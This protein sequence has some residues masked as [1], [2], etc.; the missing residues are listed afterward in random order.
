[1]EQGSCAQKRNP[2]TRWFTDSNYAAFI[3]AIIAGL[4]THAVIMIRQ[5]VCADPVLF[6][7]WYK[8]ES[9]FLFNQGRWATNIFTVLRGYL[10]EPVL[11]TVITV[12]S[13]ALSAAMVSDLFELKE[14]KW[15]AM[16]GAAMAVHPFVANSLMYYSTGGTLIYAAAVLSIWIV[17]KSDFRGWVRLLAAVVLQ[18]FVLG[19]SQ[20]YVCIMTFLP[21]V[22]FVFQILT[23]NVSGREAKKS[24]LICVFS[25]AAAF[26]AY[27]LVWRYFIVSKG[28]TQIYGGASELSFVTVIKELPRSAKKTYETFFEYLFGESIVHNAYW[29]RNIVNAVILILAIACS[30]AVLIRNIIGKKTGTLD[31]V[32]CL[33]GIIVIPVAAVSISLVVV[34]YEFYLMMASAFG[35]ILPALCKVFEMGFASGWPKR[36]CK[37]VAFAGCALLVWT[38]ALSDI[39]GYLVLDQTFVQTKELATRVLYRLEETEGFSY[40]MPVCFIGQP[41]EVCYQ[42]DPH[43]V[44]ACP[45]STFLQEGVFSGIWENSDGWGLYIYR[46]CGVKLN[47]YSNGMQNRIRELAETAEFESRGCYPAQD[48]VGIIDGVMVVKLGEYDASAPD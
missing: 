7:D 2:F 44:E 8:S 10:V 13:M 40:D 28:I 43:L 21:V 5:P 34:N 39:A 16:A 47:Y 45:G 1:M 33:L 22:M 42:H 30:L 32:L 25:C 36:I 37:G 12:F 27:M 46:Y 19:A 6:M 20:T 11:S 9:W 18:T 3:G 17:Y 15:A 26:A 48:S 41:N 31:A 29:K 4:L 35:L 38:Y 23:R 24:F 14:K